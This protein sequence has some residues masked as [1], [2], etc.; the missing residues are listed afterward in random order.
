MSQPGWN[1]SEKDP[2]DC[3]VIDEFLYLYVIP[4]EFCP[5]SCAGLVTQGNNQYDVTTVPDY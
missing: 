2:E 4:Q 3:I 5:K 1:F